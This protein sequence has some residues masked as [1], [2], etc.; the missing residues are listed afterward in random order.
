MSDPMKE[1]E[2]ER[3]RRLEQGK[4]LQ[5]D[6]TVNTTGRFPLVEARAK[7]DEARIQEHQRQQ[8]VNLFRRQW[9]GRE[10]PAELREPEGGE[11]A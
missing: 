10:L 11:A 5:R 2:A 8:A 1:Y 4:K 6:S 7:A 3:A 9:P